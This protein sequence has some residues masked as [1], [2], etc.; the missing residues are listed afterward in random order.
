MTKDTTDPESLQLAHRVKSLRQQ[1]GLTL[2]QIEERC[3]LR[4]STISKIER[5]AISPSYASLLRLAKGFD[6]DLAQLVQGP[7][8]MVRKT[9]RAVTR[10][11]EGVVH[12]IGSHDYRFLCAELVDKN[13]IPMVATV[14]AKE[15][16][17]IG[18]HSDRPD[19]LFSHDGEEVLFV[20]KGQ[21]ILH[22]EFYS[23]V[24]LNEG[25]CAY[26]DS[27]M[28]HL[29]LNGSDVDSVVFWVCTDLAFSPDTLNGTT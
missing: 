22:T 3:G 6:I 4:A 19:G 1:K 10:K 21:V 12:S 28:G 2:S 16:H 25:D 13:M 26:I 7:D 15:M 20:V 17:E 5:G 11:G 27:S 23:P 24:T 14:H 29:C 8:N 9:R 18:R